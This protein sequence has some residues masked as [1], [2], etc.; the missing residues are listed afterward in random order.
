MKTILL[1][2]LI[3]LMLVGCS[4]SPSLSNSTTLY[5]ELNGQPGLERLVDAFIQEIAGDE[6]V[7]HYFAKSNVDRFREGFITHLCDVSDG[8]CEYRGDNMIDIH[9]GMKINE[10]DFN[11]IVE[12]LINA[13]EA[14]GIPYRTQNKLLARL[15]P[16]RPEIIHR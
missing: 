6:Q 13:M 8:P 15:A 1:P 11:R 12:L 3:G 2:L 9:T 7:F 10:A 16:L 5:Q 4:S 14:E